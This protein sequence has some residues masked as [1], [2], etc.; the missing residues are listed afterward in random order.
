MKKNLFY[1]SLLFTFLLSIAPWEQSQA[2]G[3]DVD[4]EK[5]R[6]KC[7]GTPYEERVRVTVARFDVRTSSQ[8]YAAHREFGDELTSMLT[9][10]LQNV[11]CF[12]VL[13]S[14]T[15]MS[16]MTD[17]IDVGQGKYIDSESAPEIGKMLGAQAVF[18]GEITEFYVGD[19]G[20]NAL[21]LSFSSKKARIGFIIKAINPETREVIW[22]DSYE[23]ETKVP[24]GFTGGKILGVKIVG[25]NKANNALGDAVERGIIKCIYGLTKKMEEGEARFPVVEFID[26]ANT[27]L[28]TLYVSNISSFSQTSSLMKFLQTNENVTKVERKGFVKDKGEAVFKVRHRKDL[29]TLLG[30]L[31]EQGSNQLEVIDLIEESISIAMK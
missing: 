8:N 24:G 18:T 14:L 21:G 17:E 4:R 29:D 12:R 31:E 23:T 3:V 22:S 27:T 5:I 13:E 2:Q 9:N 11:N 16:D 7:E 26:E 30:F 28:T 20:V 1:Y 25:G 6:E 15:R 19:G 10:T